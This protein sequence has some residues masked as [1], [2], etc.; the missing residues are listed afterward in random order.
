MSDPEIATVTRVVV[1]LDVLRRDGDV[2]ELAAALAARRQLQLLALFVEDLDL[3]NLAGLPFAKEI[4]RLSGTERP[5]DSP[6]LQ[7]AVRARAEH[8]RQVLSGFNQ[9][10][11]IEV[12]F[13]SVR[14]PFIP[15]VLGQLEQVDIL[16]LSR[17]AAGRR[18]ASLL[19]ATP[20]QTPPVWVL[21]DGSPAAGRALAL[22]AELA[23]PDPT[24][25]CVALA[26]DSEAAGAQLRTRA[27]ELCGT[28]PPPR[29]FPVPAA[30]ISLLLRRLRQIGCRVLVAAREHRAALQPIVEAAEYPVVLV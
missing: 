9:R 8:I 10:L 6:R 18:L 11:R 19:G 20:V 26:A 16:F 12:E 23:G 17:K 1:A 22:A 21:Y 24:G 14:G 25:L 13:K 28:N 5:L 4:G 29:L 7:R 27:L 3:W 15:T 30:D 2:L